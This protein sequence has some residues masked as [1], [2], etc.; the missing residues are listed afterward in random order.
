MTPELLGYDK[1]EEGNL[2]IN[3]DEALTVRL[4]FFM[5]L[6]GYEPSKIAE[7]LMQLKRKTKRGLEKWTAGTVMGILQNERHC[8]D[9]LAHKTVTPSYLD[10][11]SVPN[12]GERAQYRQKDH[13]EG[14]ISRDDFLAAQRIIS[15]N[16]EASI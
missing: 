5:F 9:V 12:R 8:G 2:V 11:K 15:L 4:I 7:T 13:H 6:Y 3:E 16:A 10:H 14:I 1:D